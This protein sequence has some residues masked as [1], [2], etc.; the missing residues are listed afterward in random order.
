[1]KSIGFTHSLA[2]D[3]AQS[4]FEF[5][6]PDPVAVGRDLLVDVKAVSVNPADAKR[7]LRTAVDAPHETPLVLG[8]DAV[9]VVAAI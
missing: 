9:G 5:D 6:T 1:M 8:Y 7:R 3:E 2:V 4:L